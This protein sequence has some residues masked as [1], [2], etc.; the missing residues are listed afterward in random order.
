M[1][2][3]GYDYFFLQSSAYL[4]NRAVR[5]SMYSPSNYLRLEVGCDVGD[6]IKIGLGICLLLAVSR[7]AC[8][9]S[10]GTAKLAG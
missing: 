1:L 3:F 4:W 6:Y 7:E 2:D 8:R 9:P 10:A 5:A